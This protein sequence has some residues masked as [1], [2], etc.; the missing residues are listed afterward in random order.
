MRR[1]LSTTTALASGALLSSAFLRAACQNGGT[2][3]TDAAATPAPTSRVDNAAKG[4]DKMTLKLTS[5]AFEEGGMIPSQYTC[6]GQNVSPPLA[7]SGLPEGTKTLALIC[8]DPD[9]P[10]G[11]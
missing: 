5:T 6:D 4:V 10:R 9:A 8:D 3:H 7:W 2:T 1:T 11:T